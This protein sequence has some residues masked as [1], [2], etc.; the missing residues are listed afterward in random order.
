M[1]FLGRTSHLPVWSL[2]ASPA[3][4]SDAFSRANSNSSIFSVVPDEFGDM[5]E[6]RRRPSKHA[7]EKENQKNTRE[8]EK[9]FEHPPSDSTATHNSSY[10]KKGRLEARGVSGQDRAV[11]VRLLPALNAPEDTSTCNSWKSVSW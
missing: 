5:E 8:G 1:C 3:R 7:N 9:L 11:A 4:K 10:G 6:G 2:V